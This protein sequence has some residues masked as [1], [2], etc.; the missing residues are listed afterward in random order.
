MQLP[1]PPALHRLLK[2]RHVLQL[3]VLDQQVDPRDVHVYDAPRAHVHVPH[4]AVAHLPFR[5]SDEW[6]GRVNQSV[7]KFLDELLIRR[8]P[9]QRNRIPL[10]LRPESPS[11]QHGQHNRFWSFGH[12]SPEIFCRVKIDLLH[13]LK[14]RAISAI[15]A[16]LS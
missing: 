16:A 2:K 15:Q 4:F 8:L 12:S 6:P 11:I 14:L 5:Q 13:R 10:R 9:R 3:L 1:S 7:G